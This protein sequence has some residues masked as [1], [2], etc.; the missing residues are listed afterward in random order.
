MNEKGVKKCPFCGG[1][2]CPEQTYDHFYYVECMTC[3][4][5]TPDLDSMDLAIK[6]WNSR[7]NEN[8]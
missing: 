7:V 6:T 1:V 8:E 4:I 2:A 5:H 3:G